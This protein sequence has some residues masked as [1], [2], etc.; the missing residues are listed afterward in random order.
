MVSEERAHEYPAR[1]PDIRLERD[2]LSLP[3][4]DERGERAH[5]GL[6]GPPDHGLS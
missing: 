1:L 6:A 4:Q 2:R 5:R 3:S